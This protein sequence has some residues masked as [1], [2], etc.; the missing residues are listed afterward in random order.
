MSAAKK[1]VVA[2]CSALCGWAIEP[3]FVFSEANPQEQRA[4]RSALAGLGFAE[5]DIDFRGRQGHGQLHPG[6]FGVSGQQIF[7]DPRM[8]MDPARAFVGYGE[9]SRSAVDAKGEQFRFAPSPAEH[10][11]KRRIVG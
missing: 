3:E 4:L 6:G 7:S 8:A 9:P 5:T 10:R 2:H 1:K 11:F